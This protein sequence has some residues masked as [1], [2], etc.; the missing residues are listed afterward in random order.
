MLDYDPNGPGDA[1]ADLLD[2][3]DPDDPGTD[4]IDCFDCG[5]MMYAFADRCPRCGAWQTRKQLRE[6]RGGW[7]IAVAIMVILIVIALTLM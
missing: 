1:D 7:K 3:S 4:L 2:G 6:R 5:Y